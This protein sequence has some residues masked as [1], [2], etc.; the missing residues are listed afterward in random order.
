MESGERP[1]LPGAVRASI[2]VT[3]RVDDVDRL[4]AAVAAIAQDG[5]R[6]DYVPVPGTD[7][8]VPM[9]DPR[10]RATLPAVLG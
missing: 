3:T 1:P 2:G 8:Y 7:D 9:P 4:V 10:P 6:W 5:P